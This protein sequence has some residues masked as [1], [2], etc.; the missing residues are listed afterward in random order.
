MKQT[1]KTNTSAFKKQNEKGV[2]I[3]TVLSVLMLMTVMVIS[4]FTLATNELNA[5]RSAAEG[6]RAVSAKD[7]AINLAIAQ[8]REAT[9]R[10][11]TIWVSQ[12]GAIRLYGNNDRTGRAA[13]IYKLYSSS[14]MIAGSLN[15]IQ[16]DLPPNWN[17]NPEQYVDLNRPVI[18]PDPT[19]PENIARANIHFPIVDPRAFKG[20][21]QP[22]S[23]EGFSYQ[24]NAIPGIV[25]GGADYLKRLPMP[26][27]WLYI[28]SDGSVGY[29]DKGNRFV[30]TIQP[31]EENPITSRIAFWTDDESCKVNVNTASEGV[32]WDTPRVDTTEERKFAS[33]QPAT[34]EYQRYPGH[35]AQTSLSTVLFP[36]EGREFGGRLDPEKDLEKYKA[37]WKIAPGI[38]TG[39]SVGGTEK[40][41]DVVGDPI[42][43][44]PEEYHLYTAPEEILFSNDLRGG[45][46]LVHP[47]ITPE[48]LETAKFFLT[49]RSRAP[50]VTML[51]YPRMSMW[52]MFNERGS[53]T[54]FDNAI[55]FCSTINRE[56]Y[57]FQRQDA[58]SRHWEFYINSSAQ[59]ERLYDAYKTLMDD[60]IPGFGSSFGEKYG[61][62]R[63]DDRNNILAETLDYF[64]GTNLYDPTNKRKQY[65]RG[66]G[67]NFD[68]TV[69]HGQIAAICLCGGSSDHSARWYNS[70][71]PLPKGFGRIIGLSEVAFV[72]VQRAEWT[73][74]VLSADGSETAPAEFIGEE[75]DKNEFEMQEGDQLIQMGILVEGFAPAQGWTSLQPMCGISIGGGVGN[76]DDDLP[77]TFTLGGT[78]LERTKRSRDYAWATRTSN[79]RPEHWIAWGGYGGVRMFENIISFEP[80]K[81]AT[82]EKFI[83]FGGSTARDPVR[84]IL[85]DTQFNYSDTSPSIGSL[86][87][88]YQLAF[89]RATVPVPNW[90]NPIDAGKDEWYSFRDRMTQAIRKGVDMLVHPTND[91]VHS[92]VPS[93]GDYRVITSKRV[94]EPE[95]FVPHP[96]YG[97]LN[98]RH[99]HS[100]TD[101]ASDS[102]NGVRLIPGG[103]YESKP[104]LDLDYKDGTRPDFPIGPDNSDLW[105]NDVNPRVGSERQPY[106]PET[107]GD[108]DQGVGNAPDG[109]YINRPD[110]GDTRG[111]PSGD[112]YFDNNRD[113]RETASATF[114][115]NRVIPSPGMLGSLST[116]VQ[117]NVPW[118]TLLFRP[119]PPE[120][121]FGA[122]GGIPDHL[123]MD[124]FWMPIVQP[125]VISEPFSTAGKVNMNYQ[126]LP[127]TY[128]KRATG[129]HAVMKAEK[130]LAIPNEK[131]DEY[132]TGAGN[133]NWRKYIDIDET[134]EQWEE[135][136][137]RGDAFRSATEI[138]EMYLVP[139]GERWNKNGMENFWKRHKLTGDNTKERPYANL[140][141]RLTVRSN[142]FKV[143]LVAQ[144]II[145]VKGTEPATFDNRRDRIAGEYRGS[146]IVERSISPT[147]PDIPRYSSQLAKGTKPESLDLYYSYR[148]VNEKRFAP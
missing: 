123:W 107:T 77:K 40:T 19:D 128:I 124:Y 79:T 83:T 76:R 21:A 108:F 94:V 89:P 73:P 47:Q 102:D 43:A 125:Y 92:L 25:G 140:Y 111:L 130:I 109:P 121:H 20:A 120:D 98:V 113:V 78:L 96:Q 10:E 28:L 67:R 112:P 51:G 110:D 101:Y 146:A 18:N 69:G 53:R 138:C 143:H 139:E 16:R 106:D 137:N 48:K 12:P 33:S 75:R 24:T 23:I 34:G 105:A 116:G 68:K 38:G 91:I 44:V 81:I 93:H 17:Q 95:S 99:A 134:L 57:F 135:K 72:L 49:A 37:L 58:Y 31:T 122:R 147:D 36:Y 2:A 59:N 41:K 136:F 114:S 26:V 13:S 103:T 80:V 127:F 29:M 88:S 119:M 82:T 39:G 64:R 8:I 144:S 61:Q 84:I 66:S 45:K 131:S 11:G 42:P 141:P 104:F 126:I 129:L 50:E 63:F 52:P 22:G 97:A 87:Q 86:I 70:R 65:T 71:L 117:S 74:P 118:Q 6:L 9:T 55:A 4:F 1:R 142:T 27:Q 60:P 7:V 90:W 62:G 35:P 145:K 100:L 15:D 5:S 56:A 54:P 3:I 32:F 85:Y 46:R 148:I 133:E 14:S 30:G 115:P 132:K